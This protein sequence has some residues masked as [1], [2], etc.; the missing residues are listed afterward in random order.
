MLL[1]GPEWPSCPGESLHLSIFW[2]LLPQRM[3]F[4]F[5]FLQLFHQFLLKGRAPGSLAAALA[6]GA[7]VANPR[8]PSKAGEFLPP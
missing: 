4:I 8:Y 1:Q 6:G 5:I 2:Q 7:E 3:Q